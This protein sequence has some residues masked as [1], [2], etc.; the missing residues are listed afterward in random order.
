MLKDQKNTIQ[1][2]FSRSL[3]S[4]EL[5]RVLKSVLM[6]VMHHQH[7][8]PCVSHRQEYL[9]PSFLVQHR[10]RFSPFWF[11]PSRQPTKLAP[12]DRR[13][14][15][16]DVLPTTRPTTKLDHV[17]EEKKTGAGDETSF[18][19][20]AHWDSWLQSS[21]QTFSDFINHL[22]LHGRRTYVWTLRQRFIHLP[23]FNHRQQSSPHKIYRFHIAE[24]H[25]FLYSHPVCIV[26]ST[27]L[28]IQPE[29]VF[30]SVCK[31]EWRNLCVIP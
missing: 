5:E 31:I 4:L 10:D 27:N 17:E 24:E 22:S 19:L 12:T 20:G 9:N 1:S 30:Q 26:R 29:H 7:D 16:E 8:M 23:C 28:N 13:M 6:S 25:Q 14:S 18:L 15:L 2:V 21:K 11:E 3:K